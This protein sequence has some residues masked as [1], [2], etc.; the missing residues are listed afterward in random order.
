MTGEKDEHRYR[1]I[2]AVLWCKKRKLIKKS[3]V[4]FKK[5]NGPTKFTFVN[6]EHPVI[7]HFEVSGSGVGS[8]QGIP[9]PTN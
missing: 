3:F 2:Q 9:P 6:E 4:Y 8:V 5:G 1:G 7:Y